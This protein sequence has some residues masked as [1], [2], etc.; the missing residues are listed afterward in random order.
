MTRGCLALGQ[1][2]AVPAL[3]QLLERLA[4]AAQPATSSPAGG[5]LVALEA[6]TN[7]DNVGGVF[8][9]AVAFGADAV[10]LSPT[11]CDP[12]YRKAI[13]VSMGAS[14]RLPYTWLPGWPAELARLKGDGYDVV[15]LTPAASAV[16]I[17]EV[18]ASA[19]VDRPLVLLAGT[20]GAGLSAA[21]LEQATVCARIPMA[22]GVDSLNIATAVGIALHRVFAAREI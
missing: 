5:L 18:A 1:R 4:G 16:E 10:V 2:P 17:D 13:R 20:E 12:L 6:V 21:A 8:R 22:A 3:D 15:A 11:C 14:L 7:A 9:N 19:G